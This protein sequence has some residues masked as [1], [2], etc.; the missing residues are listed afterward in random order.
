MVSV[1]TVS[2]FTLLFRVITCVSHVTKPPREG[3]V[4]I[5]PCRGDH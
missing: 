1:I 5:S 4:N 3:D 2:I